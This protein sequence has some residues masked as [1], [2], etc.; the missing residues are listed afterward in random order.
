MILIPITFL[1]ACVM[2]LVVPR[3]PIEPTYSYAPG[4]KV[5]YKTVPDVIHDSDFPQELESPGPLIRGD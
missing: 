4:A 2:M 1:L 5:G 3:P